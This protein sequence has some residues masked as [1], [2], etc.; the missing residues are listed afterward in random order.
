MSKKIGIFG[1]GSIGARMAEALH[2]SGH[3]II[4]AVDNDPGKV[5]RDLGLLWG[6]EEVGVTI[7]PSLEDGMREDCEVV[8][9]ST[10]SRL[11][12]VYPQLMEILKAGC[13]VISTCEELSYPF[14]RHPRLSKALDAVAKESGATVLGTGVNPGFL[15]DAL[16]VFMTR[17][18]K[19]VESLVATRIVDAGLR[20]EPLQR[21]IGLGMSRHD[22]DERARAGKLGHVG[23]FES[24]A[25][26]ATALGWRLDEIRQ[27][28][29]PVVADRNLST[30][31]VRIKAGEVSGLRQDAFGMA[32]RTL[33]TIHLE[34]SVGPDE[35]RDAIQIAGEP[36][37]NLVITEGLH[38]DLATVGRAINHID[39]VSE[40]PPGLTTV[41]GLPTAPLGPRPHM[42]RSTKLTGTGR[43][44]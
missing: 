39:D 33:I 32:G 13:N 5:G 14:L 15:L 25:L 7:S 23:L 10:S 19:K 29:C 44:L 22:F 3:E 17:T 35:P 1:L 24:T 4:L 41:L 43:L 28:I 9:H 18:M 2:E 21:K 38:G 36:P 34:M 27:E 26:I 40:A 11:E 6:G 16:P 42:V 20:R 8:L 37:V 30:Q 31:H 12:T